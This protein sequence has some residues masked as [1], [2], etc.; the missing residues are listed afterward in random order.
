MSLSQSAIEA[1][2]SICDIES[3]PYHT[4]K[5]APHEFQNI[6][7]NTGFQ[8]TTEKKKEECG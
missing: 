1:D 3:Q 4:F 6:M 5:L 7:P 2:R 8:T